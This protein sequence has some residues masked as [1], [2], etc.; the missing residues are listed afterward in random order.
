MADYNVLLEQLSKR[1][2]QSITIKKD[3]FL[4]FREHLLKHEHYKYFRGEAKQGGDV[5]YT[6]LE[7]PRV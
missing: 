6:Y 1:E 7:N 4:Q 5:V 2:V 3:E